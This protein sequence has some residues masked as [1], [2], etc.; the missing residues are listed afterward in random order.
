MQLTKFTD[1]S[2]RILIYMSEH[3]DQLCTINEMAKW[4][5]IS[6]THLVKVAHNLV[7]LGYIKST[8]GKGGGLHLNREAQEIN[9]G[10]LI[11]DIEPNFYIAECFD[12]E[13]NSCRIT[14]TCKLKHI[15]HEAADQFFNVLNKHTLD[16]IT[17]NS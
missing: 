1:Y 4:Y 17:L 9:I 14:E 13:R 8:Q 7:K 6:K 15:L 2:L 3:P 5:G 16:T 11:R 10:Q 12:R